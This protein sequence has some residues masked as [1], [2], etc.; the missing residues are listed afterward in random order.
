MRSK[1]QRLGVGLT[2]A[3]LPTGRTVRHGWRRSVELEAKPTP[4]R[5]R[6]AV[7]TFEFTPEWRREVLAAC[8]DLE[9]ELSIR[10]A[11]VRLDE[12]CGDLHARP[13][14]SVQDS[15][16]DEID[17]LVSALT[18]A[19]THVLATRARRRQE[20]EQAAAE[21]ARQEPAPSVTDEITARLRD[22][23]DQD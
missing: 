14:V 8:I 3:S 17:A 10:D 7:E 18:V 5:M 13:A 20:L 22:A 23:T 6:T 11:L 2:L 15:R 19:R 4:V 12:V 16:F 21:A 9:S 1:K